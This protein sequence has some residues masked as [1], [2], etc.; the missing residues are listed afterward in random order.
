MLLEAGKTASTPYCPLSV[1]SAKE[2]QI[3]AIKQS[4]EAKAWPKVFDFHD[5]KGDKLQVSFPPASSSW[6]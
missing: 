6:N 4:E 1:S 2:Y 3:A 5:K